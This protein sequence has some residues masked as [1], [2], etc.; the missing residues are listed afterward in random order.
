MYFNIKQSV[1]KLLEILKLTFL[2]NNFFPVKIK[3]VHY[4]F[5]ITML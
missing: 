5:I 1:N 3:N 4:N 2:D